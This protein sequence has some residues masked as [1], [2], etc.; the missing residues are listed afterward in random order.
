MKHLLI[1]IILLYSAY[2][3]GAEK[4]T[5][6]FDTNNTLSSKEMSFQ[7]YL[8]K[9][10]KQNKQLEDDGFCSCNNN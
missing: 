3:F 1:I 6:S 8:N 7:K 9:I 10:E 4:K 5:V 2:S